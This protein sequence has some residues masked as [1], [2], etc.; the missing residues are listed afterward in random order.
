MATPSTVFC[1]VGGVLVENPWIHTAEQL[2]SE[3]GLGKSAVFEELTR[4]ATGLDRGALALREYHERLTRSVGAEIPYG[5]FATLVLD[6]SLV[7]I[8]PVWDSVREVGNSGRFNMVAL[9]NMSAEVW[10]ALERKYSIRSLFNSEVLSFELG[11][12]KPDPRIFEIALERAGSLPEESFFVDDTP[13]NIEA[14]G[15]LGLGTY[16]ARRPEDT[17]RHLRSL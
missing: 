16:L 15:A 1:D 5:E 9:S 13:A 4:L 17:A 2:A 7:Q 11:V 6:T 14:A 12:T 8:E 3:Y 10:M